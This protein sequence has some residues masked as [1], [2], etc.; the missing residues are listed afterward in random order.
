MDEIKK[1]Y[2][3]SAIDMPKRHY[4]NRFVRDFR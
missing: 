2:T 4:L 1:Y 3:N